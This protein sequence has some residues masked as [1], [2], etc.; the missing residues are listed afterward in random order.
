MVWAGIDAG[1]DGGSGCAKGGGEE[2]GEARRRRDE[3]EAE[4]EVCD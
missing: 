2:R 4:R 1:R 3:G